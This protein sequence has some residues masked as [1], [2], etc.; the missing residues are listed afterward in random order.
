M[1]NKKLAM[2]NY[3]AVAN[4][5]VEWVEYSFFL[6]LGPIVSKL[7]FPSSSPESGVLVM[8]G[9]F[10]TAYLVRPLSSL[11]FGYFSDKIGRKPPMIIAMV[12]MGIATLI[13]GILPTYDKIG[14]L[15]PLLLLTCRVIQSIA[16]SGEFQSSAIFLI[17]HEQN[18]KSFAGSLIIASASGGMFVGGLIASLIATTQNLDATWRI[19]FIVTGIIT[20]A[21]SILRSKLQETPIFIKMQQQGTID[22]NPIAKLKDYKAS[23]INI[24]SVSAFICVFVYTC[25]GYYSNYLINYANFS[26]S[27][28][29]LHC[30]LTEMVVTLLAPTLAYYYGNKYNDKLLMLGVMGLILNAPLQFYAANIQAYYL[31]V[32]SLFVYSICDA[33]VT[34][35]IAYYLYK[36]LPSNLRCTGVGFGWNLSAALFGST[37]PLLSAH[38]VGNGFMLAPGFIVI[39]YGIFALLALIKV[40]RKQDFRSVYSMTQSY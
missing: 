4:T 30:A 6:F 13:I 9:L 19:P 26:S 27:S 39:S 23:L 34:S 1:N 18:N 17:E 31:I 5:F 38:L 35:S 3:I 20:I 12:L 37:A 32:A 36:I 15:S 21:L 2:S 16:V 28:A 14:L 7:F 25:N 11:C 40:K 29:Y 22:K 24:I 8:Y 33:L 10:A